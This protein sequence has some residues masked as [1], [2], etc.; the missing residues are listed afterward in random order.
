M[1]ITA[2]V[3]SSEVLRY[4]IDLRSMTQGR[5]FYTMKLSHYEPAP[6]NVAEQV[7]AQAKREA[8]QEE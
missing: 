4:A 1:E 8:E 5:G 7:I 3:P 6:H 2:N